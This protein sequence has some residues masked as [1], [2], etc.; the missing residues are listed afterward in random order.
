MRNHVLV[1]GEVPKV[2]AV[3]LS[4][5]IFERDP[6]RRLFD[7]LEKPGKVI[8]LIVLADFKLYDLMSFGFHLDY[9]L[10]INGLD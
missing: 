5:F 6:K 10:L 2:C 1:T 9:S 4:I 8:A 3:V 7:T